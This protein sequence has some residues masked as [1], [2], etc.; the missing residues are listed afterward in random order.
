MVSDGDY[1]VKIGFPAS[2]KIPSGRIPIDITDRAH[3]SNRLSDLQIATLP[4]GV[5]LSWS[6]AQI[7]EISVAHGEVWKFGVRIPLGCAEA[8]SDDLCMI[9]AWPSK[10][11]ITL[12]LNHSSDDH[13]TLNRS[14][15]IDPNVKQAKFNPDKFMKQAMRKK[16]RR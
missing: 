7:F 15:Y 13:K 11:L 8:P 16:T 12:W 6:C 14:R 10:R 4:S 2:V 1:H 3:V 9:F 5:D